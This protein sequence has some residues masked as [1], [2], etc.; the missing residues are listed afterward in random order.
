MRQL[1]AAFVSDRYRSV[2]AAARDEI[3]RI[4]GLEP[5]DVMIAPR[6]RTKS[7]KDEVYDSSAAE[8]V[9]TSA[10]IRSGVTGYIRVHGD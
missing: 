7:A 2:T 3:A 9:G 6:I 10:A 1:L 4:I 5:F 8:C